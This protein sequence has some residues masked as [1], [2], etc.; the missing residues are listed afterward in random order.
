[1][2]DAWRPNIAI[3]KDG[4]FF[5]NPSK[6]QQQKLSEDNTARQKGLIR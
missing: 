2:D 4:F 3:L 5:K 1:M 6:K